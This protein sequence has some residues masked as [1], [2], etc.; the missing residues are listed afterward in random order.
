MLKVGE[1]EQGTYFETW[2]DGFHLLAPLFPNASCLFP[3][4]FASISSI[5][6]RYF[7]SLV[8]HDSDP[9]QEMPIQEPVYNLMHGYIYIYTHT[10]IY[11]YIYINHLRLL[12]YTIYYN[13]TTLRA[14]PAAGQT[15]HGLWKS[16]WQ[17]P[18]RASRSW[19]VR[20]L[21]QDVNLRKWGCTDMQPIHRNLM[22]FNGI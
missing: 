21:A 11:N 2:A 13:V 12:I 22:E 7:P 5:L 14:S 10:C 19:E 17:R 18:W 6:F 16:H 20:C 3:M 1:G 4:L 8:K 15:H 9:G